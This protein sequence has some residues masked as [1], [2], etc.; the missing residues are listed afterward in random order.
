MLHGL[1]AHTEIRGY[2]FPG[3]QGT[4]GR[5][6]ILKRMLPLCIVENKNASG[7]KQVRKSIWLML[8]I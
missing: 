7:Q 2:F 6:T 8:L 3:K 4:T 1:S 5:I